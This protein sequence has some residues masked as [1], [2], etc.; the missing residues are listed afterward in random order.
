MEIIEKPEIEKKT[1]LAICSRGTC[2]RPAEWSPAIDFHGAPPDT[3]FVH[4]LMAIGICGPC[5]AEMTLAELL[6]PANYQSLNS[7][8]AAQGL[9]QVVP[10]LTKLRW[11]PYSKETAAHARDVIGNAPEGADVRMEGFGFGGHAHLICRS[12]RG[13][14][15]VTLRFH[16]PDRRTPPL[17]PD[18]P[19]SSVDLRDLAIKLLEFADWADGGLP[20][21]VMMPPIP[22]GT[23]MEQ[24]ERMR[25]I[26]N[27][28]A[29]LET[30]QAVKELIELL[31]LEEVEGANEAGTARLKTAMDRAWRATLVQLHFGTEPIRRGEQMAEAMVKVTWAVGNLWKHRCSN[32]PETEDGVAEW[33]AKDV[34]LIGE[35]R[36]ALWAQG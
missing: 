29:G 6:T 19:C 30:A 3:T 2:A 12:I 25:T 33:A 10:D 13:D 15:T 20:R 4:T 34:R 22:T 36:A 32:I 26:V 16:G 17:V 7:K 21:P 8:L 9:G 14:L 35:L 11:E 18:L 24:L 23:T 1:D 28:T 5:R 31:E 27:G